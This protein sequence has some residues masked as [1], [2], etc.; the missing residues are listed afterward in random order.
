MKPWWLW[1]RL[2]PG[3]GNRQPGLTCHPH[4]TRPAR[5][6]PCGG[7]I[8]ICMVEEFDI[9]LEIIDR[10][11]TKMKMISPSNREVDV[12]QTLNEKEWIGMVRREVRR[13]AH[14]PPPLFCGA[15]RTLSKEKGWMGMVRCE[16]RRGC[17][18]AGGGGGSS[19]AGG[20][21]GQGH[22]DRARQPEGG[23]S[24]EGGRTGWRHQGGPG[25]TGSRNG[26]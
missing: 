23:D 16:V 5:L 3:G 20:K 9:P 22:A 11:V 12:G 8:P 21:R 13:G 17:Q 25:R 26:T 2:P 6:Q 24:T 18:C 15:C 10:R 1:R 4:P 14:S 7:A 19:W